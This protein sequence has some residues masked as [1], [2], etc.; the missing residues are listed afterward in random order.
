MPT[1]HEPVLLNEV[2][3]FLNPQP[4]Q[5]FI[6]CTFGGGGHSL[7]IL[8]RVKPDGRVVGI[9]WDAKAAEGSANQN[10]ILVNNNYR[11]LKEIYSQC[12]KERGLGEISGI[13]LDL[14]LSSDQ[15]ADEERGFSFH[16][17]GILDMRF[18]PASDRPT[19]ADLLQNKSA[20]EL[21]EIFEV[22]GE[23][24][25]AKII[26][27][28][29]VVA[30]DKGEDV[31]SAAMLVRLIEDVYRRKFRQPSRKNPATRV[32]QALR[33]AVNDEFGNI[34]TVLPQAIAVLAPGGRLAVISFHSG[35]DRIVKNFFREMSSGDYPAL[36]L[37]TKHPVVASTE[38]TDK[39]PRSRSAK[40]RVVEK[41]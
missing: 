34:K 35:E 37:V 16:S 29:I 40:L 28:Q 21:A 12:Q 36:K 4:G 2:L 24:P 11:N 5:N 38:E 30:R 3:D 18:D 8:N 1:I 19:A 17:T 10:L 39:N 13:L 32:L 41:I 14:G 27:Q 23:E 33:I 26:A 15:L 6:D 22:Y 20:K 7:V 9:D 25:L 31:Q